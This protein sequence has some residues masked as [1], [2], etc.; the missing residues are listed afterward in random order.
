MARHMASY[1]TRSVI[2]IPLWPECHE[3][4]CHVTALFVAEMSHVTGMSRKSA[5]RSA[6]FSSL[7]RLLLE[8]DLG[9]DRLEHVLLTGQRPRDAL[10]DVGA[11][12]VDV[13]AAFGHSAHTMDAI[14]YLR[15][16]I[17]TV[18]VLEEEHRATW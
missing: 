7:S 5:L 18:R 4:R 15:A 2:R 8:C 17:E 12:Q 6:L 10:V 14:L 1:R 13:E 16:R 9:E 11:G 3:K